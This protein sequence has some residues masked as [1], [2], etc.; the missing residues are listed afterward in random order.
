MRI[1]LKQ[2]KLL[3]SLFNDLGK[4]I[5]GFVYNAYEKPKGYYNYVDSYSYNYYSDYYKYQD[6]E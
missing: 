3:N 6:D 5:D 4:D 1:I 2:E